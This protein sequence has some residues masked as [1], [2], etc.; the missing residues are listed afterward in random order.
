MEQ[1]CRESKDVQERLGATLQQSF[2]AFALHVS[3]CDK[4]SGVSIRAGAC[5]EPGFFVNSG[6]GF[7]MIDTVFQNSDKASG[8]FLSSGDP[9]ARL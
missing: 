6:L 3:E 4:L 5:G 7:G 8:P 1:Q 2:L 9:K